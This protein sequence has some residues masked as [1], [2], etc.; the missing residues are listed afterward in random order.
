LDYEIFDRFMIFSNY[1]ISF[2]IISSYQTETIRISYNPNVI[3]IEYTQ[4]IKKAPQDTH[5]KY[6]FTKKQCLLSLPK[7]LTC[8]FISN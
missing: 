6:Y 7:G 5:Q 8:R 1:K 4:I 3:P 2:S